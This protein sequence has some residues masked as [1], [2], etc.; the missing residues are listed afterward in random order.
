MFIFWPNRI[1]KT[2]VDIIWFFISKSLQSTEISLYLAFTN[3]L[4]VA[5]KEKNIDE[6]LIL[7]KNIILLMK[8]QMMST[9]VFEI[10][11]G[12]NINMHRNSIKIA[13]FIPIRW[14]TWSPRTILVSDWPISNNRLLWNCLDS[15]TQAFQRRRLKC[16]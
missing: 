1:S 8:N 6:W 7:L 9:D 13:H 16:E 11:L 12:Q 5:Q 3:E 15:L 2:S 4:N 10:R 14:Q